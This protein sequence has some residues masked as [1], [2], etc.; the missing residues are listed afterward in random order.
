MT[1]WG[2]HA[3]VYYFYL[4]EN[5]HLMRA[6]LALCWWPVFLSIFDFIF[7][8]KLNIEII[9]VDLG[10]LQIWCRIKKLV[11]IRPQI[12]R[13][14]YDSF[15][16]ALYSMITGSLPLCIFSCQ[17]LRVTGGKVVIDGE[18]HQLS[19]NDFGTKFRHHVHGGKESFDRYFIHSF[20]FLQNQQ[21]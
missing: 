8:L 20:I 11:F 6:A 16:S 9:F 13:D 5:N 18:T 1:P 7:I 21:H 19:L 10:K 4:I 14:S 15:D 17:A 2:L 12:P 3:S